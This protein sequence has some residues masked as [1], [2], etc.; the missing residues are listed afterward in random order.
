MLGIKN[1]KIVFLL[2]V[3]LSMYTYKKNI[4][5]LFIKAIEVIVKFIGI[6]ISEYKITEDSKPNVLSFSIP[7]IDKSIP[8]YPFSR[9]YEIKLI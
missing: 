4:S 2:F 3:F 9:I 6:G 5:S 1:N 7:V 8:E